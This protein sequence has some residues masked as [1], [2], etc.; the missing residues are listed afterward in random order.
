[1]K[2]GHAVLGEEGEKIKREKAV[3]E[4]ERTAARAENPFSGEAA[5]VRTGGFH[6]TEAVPSDTT[7]T[8]AGGVRITSKART[9]SPLKTEVTGAAPITPSFDDVGLLVST[10]GTLLSIWN[11]NWSTPS[12]ISRNTSP[13]VEPFP[14]VLFRRFEPSIPPEPSTGFDNEPAT[15][16][17]YFRACHAR[18]RLAYTFFQQG[19]V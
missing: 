5:G 10:G 6:A 13:S 19:V 9:A 11:A 14:A 12:K 8:M 4:A 7:V 1:M 18:P 17:Y 2:T 16:L 3:E 15:A